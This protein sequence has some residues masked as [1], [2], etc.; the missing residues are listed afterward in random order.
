MVDGTTIDYALNRFSTRTCSRLYC[1]PIHPFLVKRNAERGS[2][3]SDK[4]RS[5]SQEHH[6]NPIELSKF[7]R[8]TDTERKGE[9]VNLY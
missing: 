2:F 9:H 8:N 1:N 5:I 7:S 3:K 4:R 6:Y